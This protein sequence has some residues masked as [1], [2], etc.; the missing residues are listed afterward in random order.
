M[1]LS[2]YKIGKHEGEATEEHE[3]A[4][5]IADHLGERYD[6]WLLR[7]TKAKAHYKSLGPVYRAFSSAKQSRKSLAGQARQ[8]MWELNKA[9]KK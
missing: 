2:N 8:M 3:L 9:W 7:V 5:Q 6:R 4:K 1:D